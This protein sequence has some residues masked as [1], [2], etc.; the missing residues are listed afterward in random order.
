MA[1]LSARGLFVVLVSFLAACTSPARQDTAGKAVPVP[2]P[3][4]MPAKAPPPPA[5]PVRAAP[6]RPVPPILWATT[7]LRNI[8]YVSVRDLA[9]GLGLKVVWSKAEVAQTL[10]DAHGVRFTFE[11]NQKDFYFDVLRVFLGAPAVFHQLAVSTK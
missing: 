6:T 1:R 10:S 9:Q 8:D 5:A 2:P 11:G 3:V 7:K 4:V